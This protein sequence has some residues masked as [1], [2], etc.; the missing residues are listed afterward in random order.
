[1]IRLDNVSKF[2]YSKGV[3]ATGFSR[4]S[5]NFEMGEFVAIT[6]E[7]GSGKSTL[8]NVIS[9]LDTYEEGEMYIDGEETSHYTEK[10]F[11]DY[12][13]RYIGNIFQNFNLV[14]S[15][16]VYQ[17]IEL[18][19]L[20]NGSKRGEVKERVNEL[21]EKVGL[22]EYKNTKASKLSG[23]QKQRVA[24]ARALAKDTPIII[25]DEPTG[26]LDTESAA[27]IIELLSN[28]AKDKLVVI[29]THNYDQVEPYVTRKIKMHDGKVLEDL[30]LRQH[31]EIAEKPQTSYKNIRPLSQVRLGVRNSFNIP[32]KFFL[33][34]F[35][36][37]FIAVAV[38]SELA[39]FKHE[40]FESSIGGYNWYF[41]NNSENRIIIKK[42]DK[43]PFSDEDYEKISALDNVD[44]VV[45]NDILVDN[46]ETFTDHKEFWYSGTALLVSEAEFDKP[47]VGKMPTA[48]NEILLEG[49]RDGYYLS[50]SYE[51]D[52]G[53][54]VGKTVIFNNYWGGKKLELKIVGIKYNDDTVNPNWG[55]GAVYV[56]EAV[57]D[58]IK[59]RI[60]FD[61]SKTSVL[62]EEKEYSNDMYS[63]GE[64]QIYPNSNVPAGEIY[65][66]EQIAYMAKDGKTIGKEMTVSAENIYFE[67]SFTAKITKNLTKGNFNRLT[68]MDKSEYEYHSDA[69]FVS[70]EDYNK[71]F[72]RNSYQSSVFVKDPLKIEEVAAELEK[73]DLDPLIVKDANYND[74]SG[75]IMRL[76]TIAVTAGLAIALFFISYFVIRII[77]K[78]R[79][80]YYSTVR[81]LGGN[82]GV[83]RNLLMIDLVT[84]ANIACLLT[85]GI[86]KILEKEFPRFFIIEAINTYMGMTDYIAI[87]A[88]VVGISALVS[89]RYSKKLF[90]KSTMNTYKEEV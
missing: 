19:M 16:T 24:I 27:G 38:T 17:N 40:E 80:V 90:K 84:D 69:V 7:S 31:E 34:T 61:S 3:I 12:R 18:V 60:N 6:G 53:S 35:V 65:V 28:I 51:E 72:E 8:L 85:F 74:G 57:M 9:G 2:Y 76:M 47:D 70:A 22:T 26:N 77:L 39:I 13:R 4:V 83:A 23:G 55:D 56:S 15:Y 44:S 64:L 81:M 41:N 75:V 79:N 87:Y 14:N 78:S 37:L 45:E 11:E 32:V 52:F 33:L 46:I 73:M 58:H 29:V 43:S 20:L 82:V 21:I 71:L 1:M 36:F 49:S 68:G 48:D 67:D 54:V 62:F 42:N 59:Y 86:F 10:D 30:K 88:I 89:I 25:A 66:G 50:E 63:H 5:L